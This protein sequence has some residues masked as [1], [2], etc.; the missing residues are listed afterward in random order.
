MSDTARVHE[1]L[2]DAAS[3]GNVAGWRVPSPA[4]LERAISTDLLV[5]DRRKARLAL[6]C[7]LVMPFLAGLPVCLIAMSVMMGLSSVY[8]GLIDQAGAYRN[9]HAF[10]H[11]SATPGMALFYWWG[12]YLDAQA[13]A[14]VQ[15]VHDDI[16]PEWLHVP[17]PKAPR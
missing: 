6:G 11:G 12:T 16:H 10:F 7:R 9:G 8:R 5:R 17:Q 4:A 2:R 1:I 15:R 3:R 13:D 14:A